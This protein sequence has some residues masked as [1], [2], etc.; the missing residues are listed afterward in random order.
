LFYVKETLLFSFQQL[1]IE[2]RLGQCR[3]G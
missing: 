2:C 1:N 3:R